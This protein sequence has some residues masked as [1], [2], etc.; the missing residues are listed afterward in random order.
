MEILHKM[1]PNKYRVSLAPNFLSFRISHIHVK[2]HILGIGIRVTLSFMLKNFLLGTI[3]LG[4]FDF[5]VFISHIW[6]CSSPSSRSMDFTS[7]KITRFT[8][9]FA[10]PNMPINDTRGSNCQ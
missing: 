5:R 8:H 4:L 9:S 3:L 1:I 7:V 10:A 6:K 2:F